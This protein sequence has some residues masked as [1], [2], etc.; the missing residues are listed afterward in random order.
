MARLLFIKAVHFLTDSANAW[1]HGRHDACRI[2]RV[3]SA[4]LSV[5]G[6]GE[7]REKYHCEH[8]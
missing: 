2:G 6:E 4:Y 5:E 8:F 1:F 7:D 3:Y